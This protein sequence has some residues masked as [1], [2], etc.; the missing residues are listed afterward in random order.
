MVRSWREFFPVDHSFMKAIGG[1]I[2]RKQL[3][4]GSGYREAMGGGAV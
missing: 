1:M 4:E 3:G 2:G